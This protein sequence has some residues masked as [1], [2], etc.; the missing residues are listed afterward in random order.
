[1][2]SVYKYFIVFLWSFF[3]VACS[4]GGDIAD[5]LD[6]DPTPDVEEVT[7]TLA[8]SNITIGADTSA[9]ITATVVSSLS[10]P[11]AN[12]LVTFV[13][14]NSDYG[15]FTPNTGQV[16]TNDSGIATI[17]LATSNVQTGASITA[18]IEEFPDATA[19]TISVNMVGDGGEA[20]GGAIVVLTL[21]DI[22]GNAVDSISTT[23]PGKLVASVTGISK[24]VIVTFTTAKGELP[25]DTAVTINGVAIVDIYAGTD[26]GAGKAVAEIETGEKGDT[27]VVVGATNVVMGSGDPFVENKAFVSAPVLSAG[28]TATISVDIID[29][30]GNPFTEPVEVNFSSTCASFTT[31]LAIISSP[32]TAVNGTATSTYLAQGCLGDDQINVNANAGGLNLSANG[33]INILSAAAGSIVFQS[34]EPSNIGILGTG[35]DEAS[36]VKFKVLDTNGDPVSNQSVSFSLNT[37]VGDVSIE[38]TVATTNNEGIVQTVVNSGTVA[39]SVRVTAVI[40]GTDPVIS[41]QSSVLVVST[42]IPDQDSFSLSAEVLNA[43]GWDRDGTEVAITARL[44]DAFNN[45]APNGTAVSFT[46]EGGS[47]E[48]SCTTVNGTCSVVWRSQLPRPEGNQL[49]GQDPQPTNFMGQKYGGRATI[50]ATAIG[51]ESFPDFN[52][53]ARFDAGDEADAFF[54][55]NGYSGN[56]ISGQPYDRKEAFVDHNEDGFYNPGETDVSE[57]LGGEL[58]EYADFNKDGSFSG[59]DGLYNGVLCGEGNTEC[60]TEKS[61]NVRQ[62]LVLVMSGSTAIATAQSNV[63]ITD[64]NGFKH[65]NGY[66]EINGK[67]PAIL[68]FTI[69]DLHNQQMPAGTTVLFTTSAGSV[70]TSPEFIWPSTN[71]NGGITFTVGLKGEDEPNSGNFSV[72]V[73]TPNGVQTPIYTLSVEIF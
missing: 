69:S 7:I 67:G 60:A 53:N 56:D 51:E 57:E 52:G 63:L 5:P 45:P 27:N 34:A 59:A 18:S 23:A 48:P 62:S 37:N 10:G 46:T 15:T 12:K 22:A 21:T 14:N 26:L 3:M 61:I 42:G 36:I 1:M 66:V 6:P 29:D 65:T 17:S 54:G 4:G 58:E 43:E 19:H 33:S 32:V 24:P 49:N 9:E 55:R 31:P 25:I 72:L 71:F 35:G 20:G 50:L 16:I 40:D 68:Q 73:T 11:L 39:T 41:S 70:T 2:K 28:G 44:A 64:R 8:T 30:E 38:P 47:I 13:L